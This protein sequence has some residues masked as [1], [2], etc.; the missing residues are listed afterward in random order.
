MNGRMYDP[1]IGRIL[2][3]DPLVQTPGYTQSYN[4]YSYCLNNPLRYTDPSGYFQVPNYSFESQDLSERGSGGGVSLYDGYVMGFGLD[5]YR[6]SYG[7]FFQ[8]LENSIRFLSDGYYDLTGVNFQNGTLAFSYTYNQ[9]GSEYYNGKAV[10]ANRQNAF[11]DKMRLT[12]A[13]NIGYGKSFG[14]PYDDIVE[15]I[16][17]IWYSPI[18]RKAVPDLITAS[19]D[20][21]CV[22]LYGGGGSLQ[23]NFLTRGQDPGLFF[24]NTVSTRY[25]IE[26]DWGINLGWGYYQDNPA[27]ITRNSLTGLSYD[28]DAGYVFGVNIWG[29]V[30]NNTLMWVGAKA[31]F[32]ITVGASFGVNNTYLGITRPTWP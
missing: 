20:F 18:V 10:E 15:I 24:S 28:V 19:F 11:N 29:G 9:K 31:G 2:S 17:E 16:K 7:S 30:S 12:T 22:A 5:G 1:V 6:G 32:G 21:S 8:Q 4:R 13:S 25:F 3:P 27:N 26:G 23:L 14:G